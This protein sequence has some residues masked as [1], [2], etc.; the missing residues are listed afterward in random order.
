MK[1]VTPQDG[2][3][4]DIIAD[5]LD[6]LKHIFPDAFTEGGIDFAVLRQLLGDE[7]VLDEGEEKYGLNWHGKKK[8]RMH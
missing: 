8:L 4:A 2:Q 5:N 3:S 6:K 1:Q 7:A